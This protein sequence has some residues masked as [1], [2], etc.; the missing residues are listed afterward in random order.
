MKFFFT[1]LALIIASI[2]MMST[3]LLLDGLAWTHRIAKSEPPLVV[4]LSTW[5]LI[6]TGYGNVISAVINKEVKEK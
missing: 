1:P 5:A 3:G 6:F 2:L 4:H